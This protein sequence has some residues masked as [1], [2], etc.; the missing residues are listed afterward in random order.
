MIH[1]TISSFLKPLYYDLKEFFFVLFCFGQP[2]IFF[3][4]TWCRMLKFY[5]IFFLLSLSLSLG[6][7]HFTLTVRL[8][9]T[10][11]HF[12][13]LYLL[14]GCFLFSLPILTTTTRV[15]MMKTFNFND[16]LCN[17]KLLNG[18]RK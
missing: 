4:G 6:L 2:S 11:N 16:K 5:P 3:C 14:S 1:W 17:F 9:S 7:I 15:M 18:D 12:I 13:E 10:T 8:S